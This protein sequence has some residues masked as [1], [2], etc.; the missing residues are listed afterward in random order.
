MTEHRE[1]LRGI[2]KYIAEAMRA[3][4]RDHPNG[5]GYIDIDMTALLALKAKCEAEGHRISMSALWAKVVAAGLQQY[6]RLNSRIEG[7]EIIYY[8][9]INCG[10]GVDVGFGLYIIVLRDLANK[11]LVETSDEFRALIKK[12]KERTLAAEDTQGSTFTL[13]CMTNS[14]VKMFESVLTNDQAIIVGT[15]GV[16]KEVVVD[17]NDEIAVRP[18]S[19]LCLTNEHAISDGREADGLT[20]LLRE[21][22]LDPE[23]YIKVM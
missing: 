18:I 23:K 13:T 1:K 16:R 5:R 12:V 7:D 6:P 11:T 22:A 2:R 17:E 4:N 10:I 9:E 19:T 14:H 8:D 21:I 15:T 20:N 3:S